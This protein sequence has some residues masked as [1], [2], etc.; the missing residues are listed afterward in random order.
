MSGKAL[1]RWVMVSAALLA[2]DPDHHRGPSAGDSQTNWLRSCQITAECGPLSCICGVCTKTCDTDAACSGEDKPASCIPAADDGIVAQCGGKLPASGMC[3]ARCDEGSCDAG[4]MCVLGLCT[5][6]AAPSARVSVDIAKSHQALVG[7]G[8]SLAY[9]EE[10]I[11]EH[12]QRDQLLDA[13]FK[14]LGL[15]VLRLRN[16]YVESNDV[17]KSGNLI[18]AATARLGHAP[19]I[20]LTSW[21]PPA[22]LKANAGLMCNGSPH[23]C[24]LAK[25]TQGAFDYKAFAQYWRSSLD[26]YAKVGVQ[27]DYIGLQN[28]PNW[29]P[30]A[31]E[32]FEACKF[33]PVE[34]SAMVS[35]GGKDVSVDYPGLAEAQKA[36]LEALVGLESR[37][38]LLAPETSGSG[39][40]A[41]YVTSLDL[42]EVA[43]FAH[44]LYGSDPAAM[45]PGNLATLTGLPPESRRP[46]FITEMEADGFGTALALH[47]ATVN[48]DAAVYLQNAL[49]SAA[50]GPAANAQA[51][52]GVDDASF[53]AQEPY[54]A[55]RHF[56]H[57]TEPGWVRVDASSNVGELLVSAW[58]SPAQDALT[59]IAI[60]SGSAELDFQLDLPDSSALGS[61][62]SE[63]TRSSF[64]TDE[65]SAKLG[66]FS[67]GQVL[68]LPA[69]A[70]M[71]VAFTPP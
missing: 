66:S 52:L 28:N 53:V 70:V 2:C 29:A 12:P 41:D 34:G 55:L 25:N 14:D 67:P 5:P 17:S 63:V 7:F 16:R 38:K 54:H 37:P 42:T 71:T 24:T 64:N 50:S 11:T 33:L 4:Q 43:A 68:K 40:I 58:R 20:F 57:S 18:A 8:A 6:V 45:D 69:R 44:H 22:A 15:D 59:L 49:L 21:T 35:V 60:N 61:A 26:A 46:V 48:E 36:V 30:K 51:V 19:V 56:A 1:F 3:L 39:N 9:V 27:P 10:D 32:V 65:R 13:V 47:Q 23:T 31:S 62:S